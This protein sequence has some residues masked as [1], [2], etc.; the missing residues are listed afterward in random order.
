MAVKTTS[1][2]PIDLADESEGLGTLIVTDARLLIQPAVPGQYPASA[3]HDSGHAYGVLRLGNDAGRQPMHIVFSGSPARAH[4][5]LDQVFHTFVDACC[6]EQWCDARVFYMV[7][8]VKADCHEYG[9]EDGS[10][11]MII[12]VWCNV[13]GD[14]VDPLVDGIIADA[15]PEDR[16]VVIRPDSSELGYS[17]QGVIVD[18]PQQDDPEDDLDERDEREDECEGGCGQP[19]YACVCAEMDSFRRFQADPNTAGSS[20]TA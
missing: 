7:E 16:F 8:D 13:P 1:D 10:Y 2:F 3:N 19:A 12:Y 14:Q 11:T 4:A 17:T 20:W 6:F 5:L 15:L 9:F 18:Y